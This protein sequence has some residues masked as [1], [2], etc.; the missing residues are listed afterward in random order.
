MFAELEKIN[1]IKIKLKECDRNAKNKKNAI[2]LKRILKEML[3]I[4]KDKNYNKEIQIINVQK[5]NVSYYK[6]I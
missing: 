6:R 5:D 1:R 2:N 4:N 3:A